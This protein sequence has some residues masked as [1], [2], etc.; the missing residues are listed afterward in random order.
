MLQV[1]RIWSGGQTGVDRAALDFAIEKDIPHGGW[2]PKGRKSEDG[3]VPDIYDMREHPTS[4]HYQSRTAL[5]VWETDAT[6]ILVVGP[7]NDEF[8]CLLTAKLC[9]E[10]KKP[11]VIASL[12]QGYDAAVRTIQDWI[13]TLPKKQIKTLNV[14]GARG[15]LRPDEALVKRILGT[16]VEKA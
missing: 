3:R 4:E 1:E 9:C 15:S 12:K 13:E 6:I 14:A 7:L 11:F 16:V 10:A 8:G 2:V 5:N